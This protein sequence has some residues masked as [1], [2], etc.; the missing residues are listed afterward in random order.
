VILSFLAPSDSQ[1]YIDTYANDDIT[2][3]LE[4]ARRGDGSVAADGGARG[5]K[6]VSKTESATVTL[7]AGCA[8]YLRD[9]DQNMFVSTIN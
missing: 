9:S 4:L 8:K 7:A 6:I 5:T 1:I 3:T 2:T